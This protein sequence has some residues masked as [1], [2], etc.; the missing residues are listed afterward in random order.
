MIIINGRH[1]LRAKLRPTGDPN[2][3]FSMSEVGLHPYN[4]TFIYIYFVTVT[5]YKRLYFILVY[6][7]RI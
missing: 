5:I 2:G 3:H 4:I 1:R 6:L 7:F